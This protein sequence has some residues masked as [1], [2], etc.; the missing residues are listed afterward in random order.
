MI[1]A[2]VFFSLFAL[3]AIYLFTIFKK[4]PSWPRALS[5]G[6]LGAV[7]TYSLGKNP[8]KELIFFL[9]SVAAAVTNLF[10]ALHDA[11]LSG[12]NSGPVKVLNESDLEIGKVYKKKS[13][14]FFDDRMMPTDY[15]G[16]VVSGVITGGQYLTILEDEEG[17][18]IVVSFKEPAYASFKVTGDKEN[19]YLYCG[20]VSQKG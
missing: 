3:I 19:P 12:Q 14:M 5:Y 1:E 17:S 13:E 2:L 18:E 15:S 11:W 16:R 4:E 10:L 8:P 20:D 7:L 9:L 6:I